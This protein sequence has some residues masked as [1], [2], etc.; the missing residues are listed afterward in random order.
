MGTVFTGCEDGAQRWAHVSAVFLQ[1]GKL[2]LEVLIE[3][4]AKALWKLIG[5]V[6]RGG[7]H[8]RTS[9]QKRSAYKKTPSLLSRI[10]CDQT[11]SVSVRPL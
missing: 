8:C 9:W 3:D 2:A 5:V 7:D 11:I 1:V 6:Q 4:S 10:C